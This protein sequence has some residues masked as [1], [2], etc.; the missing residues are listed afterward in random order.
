MSWKEG[1]YQAVKEYLELPEDAV[2]TSIEES[3][4]PYFEGCDT[5][6]YGSG[7]DFTIEVYYHTDS[8]PHGYRSVDGKLADFINSL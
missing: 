3:S 4:S 8:T 7:Q 1:F 6:G 2:I 5:C